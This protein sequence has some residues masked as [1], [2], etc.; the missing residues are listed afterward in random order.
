AEE[1]VSCAHFE[2]E[3]NYNKQSREAVY[4][5]FGKWLLGE[6]DEEKLKER[7]FQVERKEDLL[8]FH[9]R[10]KPENALDA[11]GVVRYLID[12][13]KRK[14]EELKPRNKRGLE[15]FRRVIGTGLK[16]ALSAEVP[17]PE[18]LAIR[19]FGTV[20]RDGYAVHK[21]ILGR[22]G[23]GDAVPGIVFIPA[24][25]AG[26]ATLLVSEG[27]K[28]ELIKPNG[29]PVDLI[30]RLLE[31][32]HVVMAIDPFMTGEHLSPIERVE[33]SK[34]LYFTTYN[35]TDTAE[36]VQ[37]ILTASAYLRGREGVESIGL[38]G[39]GDA[40][41]WC[42][43]AAGIDERIGR[44]AAD[45]NGFDPDDDEEWLERLY[46]PCIRRVGGLRG[47]GGLIAPRPLLIHNAGSKL[48][49]YSWIADIYG[50][51][52][53]GGKFKALEGRAS[54]DEIAEWLK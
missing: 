28:S 36:R 11:E 14:L 2:A 9:N 54:D 32:G 33:R 43:L 47:A 45:V 42:I 3:H 22:K 39:F 26:K 46:V 52:G 23:V 51:V 27:G 21:V 35:R 49:A 7:P 18:E 40:G 4:K 37:D 15:E 17:E 48:N 19:S 44:V 41:L 30:L 53:A 12:Q 16:H 38:A 13:A 10:P 6:T 20:I 8:V 31:E 34:T 24:K 25:R 50:A 1:K 5:W 29:E